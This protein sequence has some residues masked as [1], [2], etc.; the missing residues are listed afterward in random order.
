MA[1]PWPTCPHQL[2]STLA[3]R[4]PRLSSQR[5]AASLLFPPALQ[6]LLRAQAGR[7][8]AL[9]RER[10]RVDKRGCVDVRTPICA[11]Y[12]HRPHTTVTR[13]RMPDHRGR[14]R[15]RGAPHGGRRFVCVFS[16]SF[17]LC[18]ARVGALAAALAARARRRRPARPRALELEQPRCRE[19]GVA[20]ARAAGRDFDPSQTLSLLRGYPYGVST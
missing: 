13:I 19:R 15:P 14:P 6:R 2:A 9:E 17:T 16:G 1:A 18:S 10:P 12:A 5:W 11:R 8:S 4:P 3:A 20:P 7:R